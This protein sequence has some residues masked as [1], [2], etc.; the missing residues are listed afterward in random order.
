MVVFNGKLY[1]DQEC[2]IKP[3][4]AGLAH[5]HSVIVEIRIVQ[6]QLLLWE[7]HYLKIMAS[8]RM[9]R[10]SIPM[11]FTPD[12]LASLIK[13]ALSQS[14][15]FKNNALAIFQVY[16]KLEDPLVTNYH[17]SF[18]GLENTDLSLVSND[19]FELGLYKDFYIAPSLLSTLPTNNQLVERLAAVFSAENDFESCFILNDR[20][21]V[22]GTHLGTLFLVMDA[23]IQTPPV[24][25]GAKNTVYRKEIIS[26]LEKESDLEIQEIPISPFSLQKAAA[27]FVF[28]PSKGFIRVTKYRKKVFDAH[29]L[30]KTLAHK[31]EMRLQAS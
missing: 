10:I 23:A 11:E 21:E 17:I 31:F 13:E 20:K 5:G 16:P 1:S 22:I 19:E 26:M 25:G 8:M 4:N 3:N 14:P 30:I 15:Q 9:L 12:F 7:P 6:G 2:F 29:D 27:L 24:S 18:E 28:N